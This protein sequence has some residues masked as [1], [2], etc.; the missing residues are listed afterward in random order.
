MWL[1]V[2][3]LAFITGFSLGWKCKPTMTPTPEQI[4]AAKEIIAIIETHY[5]SVF[6]TDRL[7]KLRALTAAAGV[8]PITTEQLD[9]AQFGGVLHDRPA[10]T[11]EQIAAAQKIIAAKLGYEESSAK[12]WMIAEAVLK[13]VAGIGDTA[14]YQEQYLRDNATPTPEQI[15]EAAEAI[16]TCFDQDIDDWFRNVARTALAAA[17]GV[18]APEYLYDKEKR[19]LSKYQQVVNATIE[20]CAQVAEGNPTDEI[21]RGIRQAIAAAIRALK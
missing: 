3:L 18:G 15:E 16:A 14:K 17:A 11:P 7:D 21:S 9:K 13:G 19:T 10:P 8:G 12:A 20:R 4:K 1:F 5:V 2:C 6:G